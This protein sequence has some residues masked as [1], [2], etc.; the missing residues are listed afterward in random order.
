MH[1][2]VRRAQ[3]GAVHDWGKYGRIG[4]RAAGPLIGKWLLL[5]NVEHARLSQ[6]GRRGQ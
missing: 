5:F 3:G 1:T 6:G 2:N 4:K